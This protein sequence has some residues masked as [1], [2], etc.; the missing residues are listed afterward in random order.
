[1]HFAKMDCLSLGLGFS[2]VGNMPKVI[3]NSSQNRPKMEPGS[4][5]A[6][7]SAKHD[8][9][10]PPS[11]YFDDLGTDVDSRS[12]SIVASFF[13]CFV[14]TLKGCFDFLVPVQGRPTKAKRFSK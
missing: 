6:Q 5:R 7:I 14:V 13:I 10:E 9:G 8:P 11:N 12:G 4:P 2:G 3:L 1:M